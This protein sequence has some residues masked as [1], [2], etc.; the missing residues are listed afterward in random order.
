MLFRSLAT[1]REAGER[2]WTLSRLFNVKEGISRKD[3]YLPVKF[4]QEAVTSG[5]IAG[6]RMA[7]ETQDYMLDLYYSLREWDP[8]GTPRDSLIARLGLEDWIR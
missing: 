3:D 7:R 2:C 6:K 4:S 5:P 8:Q 1:M